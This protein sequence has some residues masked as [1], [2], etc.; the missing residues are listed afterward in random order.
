MVPST[1]GTAPAGT[2]SR[3][4]SGA[5]SGSRIG[6]ATHEQRA[7][8]AS[9]SAPRLAS[10]FQPACSAAAAS[11]SA[12]APAVIRGGGPR[13]G[14]PHPPTLVAAR[15]TRDAPRS[16]T[17]VAARETRDAPRSPT[18]VAAREPRAAPRSP[19]ACHARA[20]APSPANAEAKAGTPP[21]MPHGVSGP[22][23]AT[24][25]AYVR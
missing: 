14:P 9:G 17:L 4:S 8:K 18:L 20:G 15:E 22:A 13:N 3:H 11:T 24:R 19:V 25:N 12:S 16:P 1:N 2:P 10:A 21:A 7:R 6:A 23:L 5:A